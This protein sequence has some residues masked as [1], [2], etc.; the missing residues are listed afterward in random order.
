MGFCLYNSVAVAARDA[1]ARHGIGRVAIVDI[2]VHHGNGTEDTFWNDASVLYTSLHQ[3]P[4]YPGTG[5]A[6]DGGGADAQGLTVNVPLAAGTDGQAWL[7]AFDSTVMPALAAFQPELTLVSCGFDAHRDDPL[8]QLRLDT[9]TYAG[10]A[11]RLSSLTDV[12]AGGRSVWILEGGYDLD[13]L[14]DSAEAVVT[15]LLDA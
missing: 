8:A 15:A 1:Q 3:W 12:P 14:A 5:A 4:F 10:V 11:E 2:D 13:A 6:G 7:A 9:A